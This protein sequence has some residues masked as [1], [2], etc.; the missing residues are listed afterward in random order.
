[1]S[2]TPSAPALASTFTVAT[3]GWSDGGVA[4]ATN[5]LVYLSHSVWNFGP[6]PVLP[7]FAASPMSTPV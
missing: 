7:P 2:A 5:G 4:T 1:M 3:N 6:I